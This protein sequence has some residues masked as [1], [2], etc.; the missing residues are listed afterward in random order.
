M[1]E[2]FEHLLIT[3]GILK[4]FT[5]TKQFEINYVE[6]IKTKLKKKGKTDEEIEEYIKDLLINETT[7]YFEKNKIPGLFPEKEN[8]LEIDDKTKTK[9]FLLAQKCLK[10]CKKNELTKEQIILF[11]QL[12]VHLSKISNKDIKDFK[13]KYDLIDENKKEDEEL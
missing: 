8:I 12:F 7:E 2:Q 3:H 13:V 4:E 9:I 5:I 6:K 11:I 1:D 10:Q